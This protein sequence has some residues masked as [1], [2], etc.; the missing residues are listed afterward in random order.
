M[1]NSIAEIGE[2]EYIFVVGSNTTEAHP[3]ISLQVRKAVKN[4]AK[5][6]VADPR[7]IEL[8]QLAE[9][10]LQLKPGTNIALLNGMLNV[11]LTEDLHD[12]DFVANRTEGFEELKQAVAKYT[13]E[14]VMDITGV[15][16]EDIRAAARGYAK[17]QKATILYTMGITQHNTGTNNVM[18][19]ANLAML[20]GHLGKANAGVNPLRGQ[21]NVQG[22]C[23]MGA[24]PNVF[25]GYQAVNNAEL[26]EKFEK[27]WGV[28][29]SGKVGLTVGEIMDGASDGSIQ[30]MYILG[31][32]PMLS[33]PDLHHVE[34]ALKQ[35]GFLV[36]QDIF[37]TE[38]AK[39]ADVVLPG[40]SFAEKDGTFSNTERRVQ[41]VR[42]AIEPIGN[43]RPDWQVIAEIST[44]MGYP[45][46]YDSPAQIM[47]EIAQVTPSYG[48]ISY[49][50]LE[51]S[52]LQWPCPNPEHPGTKFLHEGK[53]VRG[54]GKFAAVEYQPA[55][56]QADQEYPFLLNTGRRLAHYHTGTM[57]RRSLGLE[58]IMPEDYLEL[59][60][61]DAC[62]MGIETGD[63]VKLSSR[64]GE[65][66]IKAKVT[67]WVN[68]GMVFSSFH[69]AETPINYLT[70][71]TRD[72]IAKIPA[73]KV[74][75]VKVE[76]VS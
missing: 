22:A 57:T 18:S 40:A 68:P 8:T 20:C 2:A 26:V 12:K 39:L 64:R 69:F 55:A 13:P 62:R 65:I 45:M 30:G 36:V 27:A 23:D 31:E 9:M 66:T 53:F 43:S 56:E 24:L 75:A 42:K 74:T 37:L 70:D 1:T 33:D 48:G 52:G 76:K 7:K 49:Q 71:P 73:L 14:Y 47:E 21:N 6:I 3:I 11:I 72:P 50:R 59:N 54:L 32:N 5:L 35:V 25:P 19:V 63:K 29:L 41:R 67:D 38:T 44:R 61:E 4:G 51:E 17:A 16:A 60:P 34:H 15:P 10:H 28:S 58:T 46:K